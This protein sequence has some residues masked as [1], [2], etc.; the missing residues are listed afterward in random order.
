[1]GLLSTANEDQMMVDYSEGYLEL[2]RLVDEAW[3]LIL[4]QRFAEARALCDEIV[5]T[6]RLTK[7]QIGAQHEPE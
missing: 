4:E 5:V 7:A 1:V 2:K 3:R 6:A